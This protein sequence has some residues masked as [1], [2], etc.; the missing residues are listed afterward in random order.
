MLRKFSGATIRRTLDRSCAEVPEHAHDWPLLSL[1]VIGGYSNQ[2]ELG[3]RFISGPSAVFYSAGAAHRNTAGPDGFEQIEIEFDPAW[4]HARLPDAPVARWVGGRD[5]T[6]AQALARVCSQAVTEKRLLSALRRFLKMAPAGSRARRPDWLSDINRR[7]RDDPAQRVAGLAHEA[8]LHPSWLGTAYR[9]AAGEGLMDTAAR[10]RVERA[11]RL[12]RET[13]IPFA[14]IATEAGFCD[15]S[16]MIRTFRR[17]LGR[18]PSAVREEKGD[19]RQMPGFGRYT[20][21]R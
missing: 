8:G 5:G 7:L 19:F 11:T 16:H 3:E 15:Q 13:D 17:V 21:V 10:L 1:F 9:D 18:L 6:E 20:S 14:G 4:L 2:T 12:L